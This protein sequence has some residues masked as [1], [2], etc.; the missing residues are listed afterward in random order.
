MSIDLDN[1]FSD[2]GPLSQRVAGFMPRQQQK[3]MAQAVLKAIEE[4]TALVAEAG[5]GTGKTFAYLIPA[6]L[7]GGKVI[8]STGTKTLQDQLFFRDI[9]TVREA[10]QIPVTVALLKGR[11]NYICH[12]HLEQTREAGRMASREDVIWLAKIS[13]YAKTS[14]NG[15]KGQLASVPENASIWS[16]VTSNRENCL[17]QECSYHE[18]CFVLKAR[19]EAM[20][21]DVV[22]VNHH[23][24]FADVLLKDEGAG[25]ILPACNTVI[26]DEAHQLPD[27][28]TMFFGET[29]TSGQ[30]LELA[31]DS[32]MEG[33]LGAPD[34]VALPEACAA[35]EKATRDLR[36]VFKEDSAR[37]PAAQTP[38]NFQETLL[39]LQTTL[40]ALNDHLAGQGERSE[41]LAKCRQRGRETALQ[42]AEW[43]RGDNEDYVRWIEVYSSSLHLNRTPLN[44]AKLFGP[45]VKNQ[46]KGWIF[47]SATL[48]VNNAFEHY[49]RELGLY[50]AQC[51]SWESPFDYP[52]QAVLYVPKDLPE[53]N[54]R[55]YT[56][57]VVNAALPLL[58]ASRGRAFMLFTSLKAMREAHSLLK[59]AFAEKGW[60]YPLLLQGEGSRTELLERFRTQKGAVLVASQ[61]FWEG[62][63]VKGDSLQLVVIDRLPFAPPDDPVLAA[64]V[65]KLQKEGGNPFMN[66]QLPAAAITLKQGAGRLIRSESDR[67]VLMI[68]D[69]RLVDKPYGKLLWNSLPKMTK[70]R[71]LSVVQRFFRLLD[72]GKL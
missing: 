26:F 70:T 68:A 66:I 48:S 39:T 28:A 14:K 55:E 59:E 20:V 46:A 19:K 15:D 56:S 37:L 49:T 10:L 67:G 42:L 41:G 64:R 13:A 18:E 63:D 9:R 4:R 40:N 23:L 60:D 21:A 34:Y 25:E 30:L 27:V 45:Q 12:Y 24:F 65:D 35:L 2:T 16:M 72:E 69:A 31:R 3:E 57:G 32:K 43:Q 33:I 8:V 1:L 5:T 29:I 53:P 7:A 71:D 17:G 6:L 61:T 58:E 47:T 54:T 44:I 52:R 51:E 38:E 62:I 11:S 50:D 36:L 22:V